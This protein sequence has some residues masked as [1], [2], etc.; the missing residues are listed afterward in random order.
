MELTLSL[1]LVRSLDMIG[2]WKYMDRGRNHYGKFGKIDITFFSY[3]EF[4]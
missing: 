3:V 4:R 2:D 1:A